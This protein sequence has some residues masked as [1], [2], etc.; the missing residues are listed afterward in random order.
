VGRLALFVVMVVAAVVIA[1]APESESDA[2]DIKN[3]DCPP[4]CDPTSTPVTTYDG[5]AD[6]NMKTNA[7]D[8]ALILQLVA[9]L[10]DDVACPDAA[11]FDED[12]DIDAVDASLVLQVVAGFIDLAM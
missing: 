6:C 11:D 2:G 7:I 8:A 1:V 4:A 3:P 5:D 9:G 10:I 12:G